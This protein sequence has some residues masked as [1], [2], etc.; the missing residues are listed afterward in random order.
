MNYENR[1][2]YTYS[3]VSSSQANT[4]G[5][6][7]SEDS[8]VRD[9]TQPVLFFARYIS[10]HAQNHC[11][12]YDP[13]LHLS[14]RCNFP[15]RRS[16][17]RQLRIVILTPRTCLSC[18]I[19]HIVLS[20]STYI[21]ESTIYGINCRDRGRAQVTRKFATQVASWSRYSS[22]LFVM[23][24]ATGA[25]LSCV[26]SMA[27]FVPEQKLINQLYISMEYTVAHPSYQSL[28]HLLLP[29]HSNRESPM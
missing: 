11:W 9:I 25:W 22:C 19:D 1:W 27:F 2:Y 26:T 16:R 14:G 12:R 4:G 20:V 21:Y 7:I 24:A 10:F 23:V 8:I 28:Y 17:C 18:W 15:A 29:A 5:I 3:E 6:L 13:A